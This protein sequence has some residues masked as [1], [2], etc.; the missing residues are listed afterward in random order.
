MTREEARRHDKGKGGE[1]EEEEGLSPEGDPT[2]PDRPV[3]RAKGQGAQASQPGKLGKREAA[4]ELGGATKPASKMYVKWGGSR[5]QQQHQHHTS[6]NSKV[7][8]VT[9]LLSVLRRLAHR[10][11]HYASLKGSS[12]HS[13]FGGGGSSTSAGGNGGQWGVTDSDFEDEDDSG[14]DHAPPQDVPAGCLAVYVGDQEQRFVIRAQY[15][16][17]RLFK[18]LLDKSKEEFGFQQ[19]GGLHIPCE[20]VLFE[21]LLWLLGKD[22]AA[23]ATHHHLGVYDL[24]NFYSDGDMS[25]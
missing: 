2:R 12:P 14:L 17:H 1:E 8:K 23:A 7:G 10:D 9:R 16:N 15:L 5:R 20:V 18:V 19:K 21:H 11:S 24:L 13:S 25:S 22:D 4:L 3:R 6:W